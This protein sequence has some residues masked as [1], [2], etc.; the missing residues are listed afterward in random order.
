MFR[1]PDVYTSGAAIAF[2]ADQRLYDTIY[3]VRGLTHSERYASPGEILNAFAS[4]T[5]SCSSQLTHS[6]TRAS[7]TNILSICFYI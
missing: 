1:F 3:Q 5:H 6:A 7:E 2:I 4:L